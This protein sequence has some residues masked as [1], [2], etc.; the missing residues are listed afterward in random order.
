MRLWDGG[1]LSRHLYV[2]TLAKAS[3]I[4]SLLPPRLTL[5]YSYTTYAQA[6]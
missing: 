6:M 4:V 3:R 2:Y 1:I 5:F